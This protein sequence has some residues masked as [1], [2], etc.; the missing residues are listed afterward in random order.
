MSNIRIA[1]VGLSGFAGRRL[2]PSALHA[3]AE[4]LGHGRSGSTREIPL[5]NANHGMHCLEPS[6]RLVHC[7]DLLH[8]SVNFT[9]AASDCAF[10]TAPYVDCAFSTTAP[11]AMHDDF[12]ERF[13]T[14]LSDSDLRFYCIAAL[15]D[16]SMKQWHWPGC[17]RDLSFAQ[18]A[19]NEEYD[20]NW[21]P[22]IAEIVAEPV[23]APPHRATAPRWQGSMDFAFE[24]AA[25][26][27]P[28]PVALTPTVAVA[29]PQ[30]EAQGYLATTFNVDFQSEAALLDF[31]RMHEK[32]F[33]NL[34]RMARQFLG[35]PASSASVERI[36]SVAG[37]FFDDLRRKMGADVLEELMWAA[38]NK[39][40]RRKQG[41]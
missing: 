20:K 19:F 41:E 37:Q 4:A 9:L 31:W 23:V 38:I 30:S 16:P 28:G 33:P 25:A 22:P 2:R 34:A 21:A 26:P 36:F 40:S 8:V 11:E 27:P 15:L 35:C 13:V 5:R 24:S 1:A 32:R 10:S 14:K 39:G 3:T 29:P 18:L 7:T 17:Q 12:V 6:S